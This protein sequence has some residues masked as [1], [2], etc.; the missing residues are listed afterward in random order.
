MQKYVHEFWKKI[1]HDRLMDQSA[2]L[3]FYF[4]L[5][6]F[7]LLFFL[8]SLLGIILQQGPELQDTIYFQLAPLVPASALLMIRKTLSEIIGRT[9]SFNLSIALIFTWLSATQAMLGIIEGLNVAY[10]IKAP[11]TWW[12]NYVRSSILTIVALILSAMTIFVV[13]KTGTN[14]R[15]LVGSIGVLVILHCIYRYGPQA[16]Q[17]SLLMHL[18]GT[19]LGLVLM[20]VSSQGL[21]IYLE[22]FDRFTVIYGS[23]GAVIILMIWFYFI[24]ACILIGG[25]INAMIYES[26]LK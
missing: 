24:A 3:A 6:I 19:L 18:P 5:S 14:F 23:I 10:K 20:L 2:K 12:R 25:M 4:L 26:K 15:A 16:K 8:V 11:G 9:N 22:H 21:K 1:L 17:V 7:P 13:V